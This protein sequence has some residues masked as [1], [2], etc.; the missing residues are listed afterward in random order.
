[1][2]ANEEKCI[3]EHAADGESLLLIRRMPSNV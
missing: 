2:N 1:M 3:N